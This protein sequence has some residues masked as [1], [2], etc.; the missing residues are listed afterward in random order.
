[1]A[2]K[3]AMYNFTMRNPLAR[4]REGHSIFYKDPSG[5]IFH[6]YS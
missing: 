3:R 6:T 5:T 2:V 4:E 1:M